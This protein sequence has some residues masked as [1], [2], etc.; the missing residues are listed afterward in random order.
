MQ[1]VLHVAPPHTYAPQDVAAGA[2]Q[3]PAPSHAPAG[4]Y[5]LDVAESAHVWAR[6]I[7]PVAYLRQPPAPSQA[8]SNPQVLLSA[9]AQSSWGSLPDRTAPHCPEG[10]PVLARRHDMHLPLH[11]ESQQTPSAHCPVAHSPALEQLAPALF[12][13]LQVGASQ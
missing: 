6:H 5:E 11:A 3:V 12:F 4:V 7:V 9:A 8:P 13:T 1:V 2:A 10:F